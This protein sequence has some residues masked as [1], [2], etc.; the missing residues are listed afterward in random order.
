[1]WVIEPESLSAIVGIVPQPCERE[2]ALK[3]QGCLKKLPSEG[4][5]FRILSFTYPGNPNTTA[6]Q[7]RSQLNPQKLNPE[8]LHLARGFKS[9]Y[10]LG[11][12]CPGLG[13]KLQGFPWQ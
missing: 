13:L 8:I 10:F 12:A 3:T 9:A 11:L 5:V 2:K 6:S 1:M 4:G 7:E